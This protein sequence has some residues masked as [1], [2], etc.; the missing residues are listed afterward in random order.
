MPERPMPQSAVI[1]IP[2]FRR[3]RA[4]HRL[5]QSL[6]RA[7]YPE[8]HS[9][10]VVIS[11]DADASAATEQVA[12]AFVF[13][14]GMVQVV[15]QEQKLGLRGNV[16][17]CGDHCLENGPVIVLEEDLVVG[18][19]FYRYA[20]AA[21]KVYRNAPLI[22]GI[23]LYNYEFNQVARLPFEP[24]Q[25][26]YDAFFM[27]FP[28]S[29]GQ[30]WWREPW[31]KFRDWFAHTSKETLRQDV[32]IPAIVKN[33]PETSWKKYYGAWLIDTR[34]YMVYPYRSH[35]SNVSDTG[36]A[37]LP[38]G[39]SEHQ[40]VMGPIHALNPEQST[41][42]QPWN[43]PE[44]SQ[45]HASH[46]QVYYDAF[47]EPCGQYIRGLI[48]KQ[49]ESLEV[50]LHG[51]KPRELL[52]QAEWC[53]TI[54][55]SARPERQFPLS[56]RPI[57]NNM[58]FGQ[59]EQN[60]ISLTRPEHISRFRHS[61]AT[62]YRLAHYYMRSNPVRKELLWGYLFHRIGAALKKLA[63]KAS[64]YVWL[65]VLASWG[66]GTD[67]ARGEQAGGTEPAYATETVA[68]ALQTMLPRDEPYAYYYRLL[69]TSGILSTQASLLVRPVDMSGTL[70]GAHP[71]QGQGIAPQ[72]P[73]TNRR[74][75]Y[76]PGYS[77]GAS[78][79]QGSAPQAPSASGLRAEPS[80]SSPLIGVNGRLIDLATGLFIV[81]PTWFSSWNSHIPRGGNDGVLWQGRGVNTAVSGGVA[82]AFGPLH[83][84]FEPV[85][86]WSANRPFELMPYST[87]AASLYSYPLRQHDY[88]QRFGDEPYHQIDFGDS[89]AEVR[90]GAIGLGGGHARYWF[91]PA[92]VHPM[93]LGY[94]A[95]GYWH[96]RIGTWRPMR[97][98]LGH[99]EMA[100]TFGILEN[101]DYYL[102][103]SADDRRSV[104]QLVLS[105]SPGFIKGLS[106]GM[107]RV[108]FDF[109]TESVR[110]LFLYNKIF[111]PFRKESLADSEDMSQYFDRDN[112]IVTIFARWV[113]SEQG[114]EVYGEFGRNDHSFDLRDIILQPD[115]ARAWQLGFI[116]THLF[117]S[118]RLLAVNLE[119]S[120]LED[121]RSSIARGGPIPRRATSI[122]W[123]THSTNP[124]THRGQILGSPA[125]TGSNVQLIRVDLFDTP[126]RIAVSLAREVYNNS[127][128]HNN[129][130]QLL[131]QQP[132]G[133][134]VQ[135][136]DLRQASWNMALDAT[137]LTSGL[138]GEL[139]LT[140]QRTHILNHNYLYKNDQSNWHMGLTLRRFQQGWIR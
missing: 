80:E 15:R 47:M 17:W 121:M 104:N 12:R 140:L 106:I 103:N 126:G 54:K 131:A 39:T 62:R 77:T 123:Y 6:N 33:W 7:G 55:P 105:Y 133:V 38:T 67:I 89:F 53:L 63:G 70:T 57:E 18:R 116:K 74:A 50:D 119:L 139:T 2:A 118:G 1:A 66:L 113:F 135:H 85:I 3:A 59:E 4:L 27:S 42:K 93:L 60:L 87:G 26:G 51:Q 91:G 69:Q 99:L 95:P 128:V 46:T 22:G 19:D 52:Q 137:L 132:E 35:T 21:L 130:N 107:Q 31:Q 102:P 8:G 115:H 41:P 45:A 65:A 34:H 125:G 32:R 24:L 122:P 86:T 73:R 37:H 13:D 72:P 138:L 44:A 134:T 71:W 108:Y 97:T 61:W 64:L 68:P 56:F 98:L 114:F 101:S 11:L 76:A 129:L 28:C 16:L 83:V 20:M 81:S 112:Q 79:T 110:D 117:S 9:P 14:Y 94:N 120:Q 36:G 127:L 96:G 48:G 5:L 75:G 25:N 111:N 88:V 10:E 100:Y 109:Y 90:L 136:N 23:A 43:F 92:T 124:A 49:H 84:R 58:A 82:A 78:G 40:V 30:L 29:S